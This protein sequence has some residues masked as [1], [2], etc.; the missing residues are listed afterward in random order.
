[1]L[2]YRF[3]MKLLLA[4]TQGGQETSGE[5]NRC[6]LQPTSLPSEQWAL[7]SLGRR[8]LILLLI[9]FWKCLRRRSCLPLMMTATIRRFSVASIP[10]STSR[11]AH[12]VLRSLNLQIRL[13]RRHLAKMDPHLKITLLR[14]GKEYRRVCL[15]WALRRCPNKIL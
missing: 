1:M 2:L 12:A 9:T 15:I 5:A 7:V 11:T 13:Q 3:V 14:G 8:T 10:T 6:S 4:K